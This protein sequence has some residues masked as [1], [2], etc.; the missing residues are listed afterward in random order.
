MPLAHDWPQAPK[1]FVELSLA[2][3]GVM[4]ILHL[5]T[6][7]SIMAYWSFSVQQTKCWFPPEILKL[8]SNSQDDGIRKWGLGEV[9]GQWEVSPHEGS[10]SPFRVL[11]KTLEI[12]LT[13]WAMSGHSDQTS[14]SEPGNWPSADPKSVSTSIL[15]FPAS[16][17]VRNKFLSFTNYQSMVFY[18]KLNR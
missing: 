4:D 7:F 9:T 17:P 2:P 3:H 10:N 5:I 14:L 15:Y 1:T 16:R 11:L 18:S 12:S 6:W 8:K 13:P